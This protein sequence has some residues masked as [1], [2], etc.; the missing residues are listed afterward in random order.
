MSTAPNGTEPQWLTTAKHQV[1]VPWRYD[2][3]ELL[4]SLDCAVTAYETTRTALTQL[5]ALCTK[6]DDLL[7]HAFALTKDL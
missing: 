2:K 4:D 3:D 6:Y 7:T 5:V 1:D